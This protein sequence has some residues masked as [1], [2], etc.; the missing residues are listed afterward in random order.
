MHRI[1]ENRKEVLVER[2]NSFHKRR[3]DAN[4]QI[5]HP[6]LLKPLKWKRR[7]KKICSMQLFDKIQDKVEGLTTQ[8]VK[9]FSREVIHLL[10]LAKVF[11]KNDFR[12]GK[13]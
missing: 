5:L 4:S 9:E 6:V 1:L 2:E 11:T 12:T 8:I 3:K 13:G 10:S 7:F